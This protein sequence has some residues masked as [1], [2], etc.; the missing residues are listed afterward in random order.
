MLIIDHDR[1]ATSRTVPASSCTALSSKRAQAILAL[2]AVEPSTPRELARALNVHEQG[3]YYHLRRLEHTG[4]IRVESATKKRGVIAQR[5]ELSADAISVVLREPKHLPTRSSEHTWLSPFIEDGRL[6]ARIIVGSPDPHG[7]QQARSR[8][9]YFGMDLA[10][11]LGTLITTPS[12]SVCLDTEARELEHNLIIIGGPIVNTIAAD[13]N[14]ASPIRFDTERKRIVSTISNRE[15]LDESTGVI[16]VFENPHD[17]EKHV[18]W[19]Y[20]LRNEGTRAAITAFT[21]HYPELSEGNRHD[22]SACRVVSGLDLDSDGI[23][24]AVSFAE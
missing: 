7:P 24:D 14:H 9:G 19:V 6:N 5:Y 18:L 15:Y 21:Q 2:L 13:V 12:P 17:T 20:G 3:V 22:G 8:D 1:S 16:S 23:V 10:L 4:I 11:F